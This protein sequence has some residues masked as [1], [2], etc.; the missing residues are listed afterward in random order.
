MFFFFRHNFD[1]S[2]CKNIFL[3]SLNSPPSSLVRAPP[4][5]TIIPSPTTFHLCS[6][7]KWNTV[8]IRINSQVLDLG[9]FIWMN[10]KAC[11][12]YE[13][14]AYI[15]DRKNNNDLSPLEWWRVNWG[16]YRIVAR[17]VRKWLAVPATSTPSER[18]FLV[19]RLVDTAERFN[20]LGV[21]IEKQVF[22]YMNID[23]SH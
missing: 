19:C 1:R 16:K 7:K 9:W 5:L 18:V 15:I 10:K 2:F 6:K 14:H 17:V 13:V 23:F 20:L 11:V 12:T 4:Q 3:V 8:T 21:S 22:R